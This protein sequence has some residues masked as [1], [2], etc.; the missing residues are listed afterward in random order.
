MG[1]D[2]TVWTKLDKSHVCPPYFLTAGIK[3]SERHAFG[4]KRW[5]KMLRLVA[6][7]CLITLATITYI[8]YYVCTKNSCA[9]VAERLSRGLPAV[10][11]SR[12]PSTSSSS[13]S[14]RQQ[15]DR[16]ESVA[17]DEVF[18]ERFVFDITGRD[19]IVFLHIQKTGGTIFGRHLVKD[20]NVPSPCLC[21]RKRKR[22]DCF[23]PNTQNEQWLFSRYSTGWKCGL[24]ADWTELTDCVEDALNEYEG[25]AK[26]RRLDLS[27]L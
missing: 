23:R 12:L 18:S 25:S 22:C 5:M 20:L 4:M 3:A 16:I 8:N 1:Y 7:L 27:T 13:T 17:F 24:H 10:V 15:A 6:F 21:P 11:L 9:S 14:N 2:T 26:K 19:V